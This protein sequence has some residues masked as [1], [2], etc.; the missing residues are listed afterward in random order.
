MPPS[1]RFMAEIAQKIAKRNELQAEL[2]L[3]NES[4]T[5]ATGEQD[6]ADYKRYIEKLHEYNE[7]KDIAQSFLGKLAELRGSTLMALYDEFDLNKVS[8]A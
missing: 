6:A 8:D 7:I 4:K 2:H 5:M 3:I 1:T